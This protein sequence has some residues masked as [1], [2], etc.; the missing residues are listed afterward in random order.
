[1]DKYVIKI[2][3]ILHLCHCDGASQSQLTCDPRKTHA[4]TDGGEQHKGAGGN[5]EAVDGFEKFRPDQAGDIQD[6]P[7]RKAASMV[8]TKGSRTVPQI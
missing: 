8:A 3:L 5:K 2:R 7:T 6:H 1:M 4:E